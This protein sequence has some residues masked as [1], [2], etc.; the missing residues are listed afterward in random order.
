MST[1]STISRRIAPAIA[2][3]LLGA[4]SALTRATFADERTSPSPSPS[5]PAQNRSD[6]GKKTG[7]RPRTAS[8][9]SLLTTAEWKLVDRT[10]DRGLRFIAKNQASDGSF[11]TPDT[12]RPGVTSLCV[13]AMLARGH[14][15]GKG[16]YG[17]L[18]DRSIDYILDVQDPRS[19]AI[20]PAIYLGGDDHGAAHYNHGISGLMLAEIYGMADPKRNDR[21]RT[22]IEK[23][24]QYTRSVQTRWKGDPND[25]GGWRYPHSY[26]S[27]LSVT[28]WQLM[29]YRSA[30]NADFNVPS[31]WIEEAMGYVHRS[32][33]K[34]ERAFVYSLANR[35]T[36]RGMVGAGVVCLELGGEHQSETAKQAADWIL[37]SSFKPYNNHSNGEDRYHYGAFYCS[38][39]MFQLGGQYWRQFFPGLLQVM[40]DAQHED[41]SWDVDVDD[42]SFGTVY[43]TSLAVLALATPYQLLPIYQR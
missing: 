13:M 7:A 29:F 32:F 28:C 38:Q 20:V 2:V 41:G 31:G 23:A 39:A 19:G 6:S 16:R 4:A 1:F 40:A 11:L 8:D 33:D 27:D 5:G 21:I 42:E 24:L 18:I 25:R 12:A 35:Y 14:Q 22:A 17:P 37:R 26:N 43:T 15:P 34:D 36:T 30:R 9:R 10:V 3:C